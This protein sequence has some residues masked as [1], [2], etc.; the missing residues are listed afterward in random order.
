[1]ASSIVI[2]NSDSSSSSSSGGGG[3]RI[4]A[5]AWARAAAAPSRVH[6]FSRHRVIK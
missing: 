2:D 3:G 5:I 6:R 4:G 1:V